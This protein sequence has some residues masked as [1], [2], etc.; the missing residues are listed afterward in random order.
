MHPSKSPVF[1]QNTKCTCG[2]NGWYVGKSPIF[3]SKKKSRTYAQKRAGKTPNTKHPICCQ[4]AL[5]FCEK[6]SPQ[7]TATHC[8]T[9]CTLQHT[10]KHASNIL[11]PK[12][13]SPMY[14]CKRPIVPI[15]IKTQNAELLIRACE[16]VCMGKRGQAGRQTRKALY[17]VKEL[18]ISVKMGS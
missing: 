1:L 6:K 15:G 17:V 14:P 5:C 16:A 9:L 8:N 2:N 13:E 18:S 4:R 7:H 12:K 10:A 11:I 3:K